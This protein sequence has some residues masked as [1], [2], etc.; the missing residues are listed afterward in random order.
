MLFNEASEAANR[1]SAAALSVNEAIQ[2][3]QGREA[4]NALI[5]SMAAAAKLEA[6]MSVLTT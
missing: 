2:A 6:R 1:A 5:D 3:G 4:Y